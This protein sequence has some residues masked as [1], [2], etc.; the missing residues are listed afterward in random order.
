MMVEWNEGRV[1]KAVGREADR[2]ERRGAALVAATAKM[3]VPKDE[4]QLVGEIVI[5]KSKYRDGGL[6]VYAQPP[7]TPSDEYY[8]TYVEFGHAAPYQGYASVSKKTGLSIYR[9]RKA[10]LINKT[11]A[12]KPF[13][14][15]AVKKW[16]RVVTE[17]LKRA[18]L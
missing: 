5:K 10:G 4:R 1:L 16:R 18:I 8:A 7:G 17:M 3:L 15:P 6:L 12:P 13:M 2:M 14:R 11:T 9:L